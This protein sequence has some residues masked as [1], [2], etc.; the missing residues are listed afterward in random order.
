MNPDVP[1]ENP[2]VVSNIKNRI[3]SIPSSTFNLV[4][5]VSIL[6]L[7]IVGYVVYT[8]LLP[9]IK[10][11]RAKVYNTNVEDTDTDDKKNINVY[12]FQTNWCPHCKKV[13]PVWDEFADKYNGKGKNGYVIKIDDTTT[14]DCDS[15][16]G[17][18]I[19]NRFDIDSY[20]TIKAQ[21]GKEVIEFDAKTTMENLNK[22]MEEITK[23]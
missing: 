12:L 23:N 21:K 10:E 14:I 3:K 4:I 5:G 9:R 19:A 11:A 7:A 15:T 1:P 2:S 16:K 20:P 13:K 6:C 17:E 8:Y 22:F 18:L